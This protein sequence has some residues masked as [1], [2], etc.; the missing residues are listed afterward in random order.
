MPS[1]HM[2]S[3][4]SSRVLVIGGGY[5]G[6]YVAMKL[7]QKVAAQG[8]VVTVVDPRPYMTYQPLLP[9]VA[10]G[11]VEARHV[12]EALQLRNSVLERIEHASLLP[13]GSPERARALTVVGV[14]GGFA[15]IEA[16]TELEDMA[17]QAVAANP[18]VGAHELR[19]VLV[20]AMGRVMPEVTAEQAEW[21]VEHLRSR[22]IEV[23]LDTSLAS[24]VD[25]VLELVAM[26]DRAPARTLEADTLLWTAGVQPAP[27]A[28]HYGF[29][30][31]ARGRVTADATLRVLDEAGR[32]VPGAWT[33]GDVAAVPD[34]TG[35]G[36]GGYCVPNA[37]H[38]VRQA[39]HLAR[40]LLA[41]RSGDGRL[42][43][44]RHHNLGAVAGFGRHQGVGR[45][46]GVKLTGAPAWLAH[47]GYHGAAVP[48]WERKLRVL[49][50][51]TLAAALGRD[52]TDTSDVATP[53]RAFQD[54][55]SPPGPPWPRPPAPET[56]RAA[57]STLPPAGSAAREV[58]GS[59]PGTVRSAPGP[60]APLPPHPRPADRPPGCH[61]PPH[62]APPLFPPALARSS[63]RCAPCTPAAGPPLG[64]PPR[65][66][67]VPGALPLLHRTRDG[68]T[69]P[70][71][72]DAV[73][74]LGRGGELPAEPVL[75]EIAR[76]HGAGV[77]QVV[78]RRHVQHGVVPIPS[79]AAPDRQ[80]R[81]ARRCTAVR[82]ARRAP[83]RPGRRPSRAPG[84]ISAARG[85]LRPRP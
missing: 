29:P 6:L 26:P 46:L 72:A 50:D 45:I 31:D 48:T 27:A 68:L 81:A 74:P 69:A 14:G 62:P 18:R 67:R 42:T 49:T 58:P 66:R 79:S 83:P 19:F 9:E 3:G 80:P 13:E 76:A 38:A 52:T 64:R 16:I 25:G 47:R 2:F 43:E 61:A 33:A 36:V 63:P 4:T 17:R 20:E 41:V 10:S 23:L 5:V 71:P 8:G 22:G 82:T 39:K 78:L 84:A 77:G 24:A 73:S 32:P 1:S 11:A 12:E 75:L 28:R 57:G 70:G 34:L 56:H 51:W 85:P 53:Y 40:N 65:G 54:A 7:Q 21:V 35:G 15:G 30:L 44:Y 37:Q 55:A 60:T 59:R